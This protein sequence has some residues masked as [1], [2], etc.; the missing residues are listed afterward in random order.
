[1]L[2]SIGKMLLSN[3]SIRYLT[4]ALVTVVRAPFRQSP[5]WKFRSVVVIPRNVRVPDCGP[6]LDVLALAAHREVLGVEATG[7]VVESQQRADVADPRRGLRVG[8]GDLGVLEPDRRL[9]V[10]GVRT[11][12]D[13]PLLSGLCVVLLAGLARLVPTAGT[14]ITASEM[15]SAAMRDRL[16]QPPSRSGPGWRDRGL[17]RGG[18]GRPAPAGFGSVSTLS[19]GFSR[20]Q[21][22][23]R[24]RRWSRWFGHGAVGYERRTKEG[25]A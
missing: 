25:S 12:S 4:C 15:T 1:M 6:D 24:I 7:D 9:E 20:R 17:T 3:W 5:S 18:G 8:V 19:T 21:P 13:P 22:D 23:E 10:G 14:K 16:M 2:D 11:M